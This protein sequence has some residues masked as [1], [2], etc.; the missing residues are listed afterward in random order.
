[1]IFLL[2]FF[3]I[4]GG[5]CLLCF[6]MKKHFRH[7]WPNADFSKQL[8]YTLRTCGYLALGG[9]WVACSVDDGWAMGLIWFAGLLSVAVLLIAVLLPYW[10]RLGKP[11]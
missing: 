2:A 8:S 5:S 11:V 3:L 1:M 7:L 9:G 10:Q 6:S 4:L